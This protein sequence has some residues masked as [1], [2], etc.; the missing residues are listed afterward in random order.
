LQKFGLDSLQS[1]KHTALEL[2]IFKEQATALG[3]AGKKLRLSIQKFASAKS[4][5]FPKNNEAVLLEDMAESFYALV[6]QREFAGFIE[7]NIEWV[8]KHYSIPDEVMSL[9]GSRKATR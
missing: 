5:G 9:M 8:R 3:A 1:Q 6:I 2:E 4:E 7:A